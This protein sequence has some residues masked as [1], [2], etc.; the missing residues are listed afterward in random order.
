M[1]KSTHILSEMGCFIITIMDF[2]AIIQL[3][4]HS[5]MWISASENK[6]LSA[7]LLLDLSAAFD[8]VDHKILFDKLRIY[9]FA[10]ESV[11]WFESYL[12]SRHQV[13]QVGTKFSDVQVLGDYGVPQGSILGPL[14]F[15]IF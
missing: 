8:I 10:E 6:E 13:V 7:A 12:K 3:Q 15:L 14:I 2:W 1:N 5:S 11:N 9:N 4:Q